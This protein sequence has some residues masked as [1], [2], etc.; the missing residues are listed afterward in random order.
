MNIKKSIS[1]YLFTS[2]THFSQQRTLELSRRPFSNLEEMDSV[3]LENINDKV[4]ELYKINN[5]LPTLLHLG[6]FGNHE[7]VKEIN[8]PV[9]LIMGNY[10]RREAEE[11]NINLQEY[12][13]YLM[14][15]YQYEDVYTSPITMPIG[16]L[17]NTSNMPV[18]RVTLCHEPIQG[19][20]FTLNDKNID[21]VLY[22]HIHGRQKVKHFGVDVGVDGSNYRPN[23]TD[24]ILFFLNALDKGYYDEEVWC[25]DVAWHKR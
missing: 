5:E 16:P 22:G 23:T 21:Y 24:D 8:C 12:A 14:T 11:K 20:K 6:D 25:D 15:T 2:D 9:I 19:Y 1:N 17:S 18:K 3:I 13:E 10:E 7:L 4:R